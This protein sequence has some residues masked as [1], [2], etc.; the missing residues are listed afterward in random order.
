MKLITTNNCSNCEKVKKLILAT[1]LDKEIEIVLQNDEW[2]E[3]LR[4]ENVRMFPCLI[5]KDNKVLSYGKD[6]G[7]FIAQ[8]VELIKKREL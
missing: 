1:G 8:N 5:G 6:T 2:V 7:Y 3:I 4:K